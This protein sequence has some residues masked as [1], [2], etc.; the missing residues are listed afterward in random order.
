MVNSSSP[1][2]ADNYSLQNNRPSVRRR[3]AK[4]FRRRTARVTGKLAVALDG[5]V[6]GS[7]ATFTLTQVRGQAAGTT[8]ILGGLVPIDTTTLVNR[9][10][11]STDVT[12]LNAIYGATAEATYAT[13]ASGNG[14]GGKL[15][16]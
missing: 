15:G 11:T 16:F 14:G 4:E 5:S 9:A 8:N 13:D 3:M 7:T 6:T 10:T 12:T 2:W 1:F